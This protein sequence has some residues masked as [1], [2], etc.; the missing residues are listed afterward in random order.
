MAK[1]KDEFNEI[2]WVHFCSDI[3][4]PKL[5]WL[6]AQLDGAKIPHRRNGTGVKGC[7][8][9]EVDFEDY[10]TV[11]RILGGE[12]GSLMIGEGE[13]IRW[14][15]LPDDHPVFTLVAERGPIIDDLNSEHMEGLEITH[16]ILVGVADPVGMYEVSSSNLSAMGVQEFN[17]NGEEFSWTLY[18]RFK[19]GSMYRYFPVSDEQWTDLCIEAVK[20]KNGV[21]EASLGS[22]YHHA[23][24]VPADEGKIQ[25]HR[26]DTQG[27][28]YDVLPKSQRKSTADKYKKKR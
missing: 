13:S 7:S 24:K 15:D 22:L 28:W 9:L 2:G 19:G 27:V 21:Q 20:A 25:C 11:G 23:I 12:I 14:S 1:S 17:S 3:K 26:Q 18:V 10:A 8:I 6:E 4:D 16:H 5:K